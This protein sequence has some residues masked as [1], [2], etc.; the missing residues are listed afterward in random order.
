METAKKLIAYARSTPYIERFDANS[1]SC[2]RV[3]GE[4]RK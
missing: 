2:A 1:D 4:I 3:T